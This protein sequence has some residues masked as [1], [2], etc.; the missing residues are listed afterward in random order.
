MK[1]SIQLGLILGFS[2]LAFGASKLSND[3]PSGNSSALVNVIV[4]FKTPPTKDELKMFGPY[5]QVKKTF[6][7]INAIFVTVSPSLLAA[8]QADPNVKYVSPNRPHRS[9]LDFTTA[10]VSASVAWQ[11]GWTGTGVGIAIIDSG[12]ALRHDLTGPDGVTSR[13]IYKFRYRPDRLLRW[14]RPRDTRGGH[15]RLQWKGLQRSRLHT[16]LQGCG[17]ER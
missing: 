8:L 12:I 5:G 7:S 1:K 14:L 11:S 15:R 17:P 2:S 16:H 9:F 6:N 10:A 13:V 4:Q 3:L